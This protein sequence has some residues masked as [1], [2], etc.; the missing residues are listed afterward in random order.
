MK[1]PMFDTPGCAAPQIDPG[2][3]L[4]SGSDDGTIRLWDLT[5]RAC[6]KIFT[7]HV[8][9]VQSLKL[10]FADDCSGEEVEGDQVK[11]EESEEG[12]AV[13][14]QGKEAHSDLW[15]FGQH[16]KAVGHRYGEDC[17]DILRA[18]RRRLDS[19]ERQ[20]AAGQWQP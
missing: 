1:S 19:C 13:P 5:Q 17:K 15:K 12:A 6:V 10:L 7:G 14:D 2:K 16:H 11:D 9:Q 18:Y 8:G 20:N 3:M 4:F